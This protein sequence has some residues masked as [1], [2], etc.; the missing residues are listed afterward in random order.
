MNILLAS[1]ESVDDVNE[2]TVEIPASGTTTVT[3]G[4][5]ESCR[6]IVEKPEGAVGT[7]E[8]V[9]GEETLPIADAQ[10]VTLISGKLPISFDFYIKLVTM[11]AWYLGQIE[12]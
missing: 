5:A 2:A 4:A 10:D 12:S 1:G 7:V 11:Y 9:Q 8:I 3:V 6:L